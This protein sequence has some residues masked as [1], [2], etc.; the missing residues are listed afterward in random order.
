MDS[1]LN[2][3]S[4]TVG[5][6]YEAGLDP[7]RWPVA[8]Q[9]LCEEVNAD[10]AQMLYLDTEEHMIS[11]ACGYGFDPYAHNIGASRFRRHFAEDP[12]AQYGINHLNE[13][14][15]DRRVIEPKTLHASR[16]HKEIRRPAD[17]EYL[18]TVFLTDDSLDW[19]GVCF[20]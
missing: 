6:I 15:S 4:E 9:A 13:V 16:M 14:F 2:D 3:F 12:V 11:F 19:T 8:L 17:M 7:D 5:L 18:L 1:E 10:K 20:F